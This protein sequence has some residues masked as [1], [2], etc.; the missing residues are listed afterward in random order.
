MFIPL[1]NL[2]EWIAGQ[3]SD[4]LIYRFFPPGQKNLGNINMVDQRY[5]MLDWHDY[6]SLVPMLC[7]DQEPLNYD[8]YQLTPQQ[9]C[10]QF[11]TPWPAAQEFS[12][13]RHNQEYWRWL[14]GRNMLSAV[15]S[16]IHDRAILLHSEHNS[17]ELARYSNTTVGAFWWSHAMI[18]RDWYRFAQHDVRLVQ[19]P[20]HQFQLE[21]NIYARAWT[22]TREYRLK[23]LELLVQ[24][25]L[26]QNSRVTF[27]HWDHGQHYGS[28]QAVN[29]DLQITTDLD[30]LTSQSVNSAASATYTP[31]HYQQCAIDVVLET[32]FDD[33]RVHLTEKIL[34]PLACGQPFMLVG[35]PGSLAVLK[36]YGFQTFDTWIDESYDRIQSPGKRLQ[37]VISEMVRVRDMNRAQKT[38]LLSGMLSVAQ[39]NKRHFFSDRFARHIVNELVENVSQARNQILEQHQTGQNWQHER[40][41][42]TVPERVAVNQYLQA[43]VPDYRT[44]CAELLCRFRNQRSST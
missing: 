9:L 20:A 5:T 22:G 43:A 29:P 16:N 39:F 34:R 44:S 35:A 10:E 38:E 32:L 41:I 23:F 40:S 14:A 12:I 31:E 36:S 17:S 33:D 37:A 8:L 7:H 11:Q 21:F 4:T 26:T 19:D 24:H 28:H 2:Y 13:L 25:N 27:D 6:M 18:A 3:F 30:S 1:D 15:R 42:M